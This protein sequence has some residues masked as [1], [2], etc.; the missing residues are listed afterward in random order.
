MKKILL[1]LIAIVLL[2]TVGWSQQNKP[3]VVL[4]QQIRKQLVENIIRELKAKY[5][6][7]EKVKD[8]ETAL[9]AKF[10]NGDYDKLET[11]SRFASALTQDLRTVAN[12][13]H[14]FVTYDP[15]LEK[16][17]IAHPPTPSVK[18]EELPPTPEQIAEMRAANFNFRKLEILRGNVG[19]LDL[20]SFMDL[21]YAKT[22][23]VGAMS[24]L[25]NS[26]AVIIDLRKNPGGYV[27]L[28]IFLASYFFGAKPVELLS[29]Y[30]RDS[31]VTVKESTLAKLPGKRMPDTPLYILT[32]QGTG[33]AAERFAFIM[34]QRNRA[35]LIGEKTS[36]ADYGNKEYPIGEG[37]VFYV[38]VFSNF[39]GRPKSD[40]QGKGIEPD[41]NVPADKALGT[42]HLEAI[43]TLAAKAANENKKQKLSW[44]IPL[45]DLETNGA[46][47]VSP[48]LLEK[49]AGK[50][51]PDIIVA[52][53]GDQLYFTGASGIKRKLSALADDYFL[54][55][56]ASV[57]AENQARV[58]FLVN[59]KGEV[60]ELQ[61]VISDGRAFSRVRGSK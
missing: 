8:I 48:T 54:I 24:F 23:A 9:R 10:Q 27:N 55:E 15:E 1:C 58:K 47:K 38:S 2:F 20:R 16:K 39:D 29:R 31:N 28:N 61:L 13:L 22:T 45:L 35:T 36:G 34:Q 46:K 37:F 33:S 3:T 26:D 53:E 25:A 7:P 41:I 49:Y 59:D 57:P 40:W 21:T 30:H 44:L 42:A 56:D 43:K 12:D 32:S 19:Y 18:L 60:S 14:L 52:L 50:Y 6:V 51:T 5:V 4:D 11:P 17:L